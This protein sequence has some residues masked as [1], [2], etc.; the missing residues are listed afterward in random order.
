MTTRK[1]QKY[2][3]VLEQGK[4]LI[5]FYLQHPCTAAFE[6]LRSD[7]APIQRMV[8]RD[9]WFK[10]YVITVAGRGFG[11]SQCVKSLTH[12]R[13]KGLVYLFE[14]LPPIPSYLKDG[15]EEVIGL[16]WRGL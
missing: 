16:G 6:L 8:F 5:D 2:E 11:K 15:D 4:E 1:R 10:D 13:D 12:F 7:L 9:M 3:D 14:E